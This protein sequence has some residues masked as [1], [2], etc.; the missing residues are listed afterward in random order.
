MGLYK[1]L[2]NDAI[3]LIVLHKE[4]TENKHFEGTIKTSFNEYV[5][6]NIYNPGLIV[7]KYRVVRLSRKHCGKVISYFP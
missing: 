7:G 5:Q 6:P 1:L 3:A 4:Q 2:I